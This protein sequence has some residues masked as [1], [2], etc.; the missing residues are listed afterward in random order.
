MAARLPKAARQYLDE[1]RQ[2]LSGLSA[3]EREDVLAHTRAQLVR[4][5]RRGRH[6]QD[7]LDSLGPVQR[8]AAGFERVEPQELKVSSGFEFL[9]RI[10]AWPTFAFSLLTAAVLLFAP[11]AP[12]S[13]EVAGALGLGFE[14]EVSFGCIEAR[15]AGTWFNAE[16]LPAALVALVPALFSLTPLILRDKAAIW[17]QL[18]GA[19]VMSVVSILAGL[20]IGMFYW[21]VTVLLYSQA[22][23]PWVLLRS[24]MGRA[25]WIWRTIGAVLLLATL[26]LHGQAVFT[27]Y[28]QL[29]LLVFP[30]ILLLPVFGHF[31]RWWWADIALIAVGLGVII[32]ASLAWP[33]MI[34]GFIAGGLFFIVGHLGLAGNMWY[35]RSRDLLALL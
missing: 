30:A 6:K 1:L 19:V 32:Y 35:R 28:H 33:V 5:P 26:L 16:L 4:L 27:L 8:I 25:G 7:I 9:T 11:Q 23:V 18:L 12:M 10:L 3:A 14:G 17:L 15:Q 31:L 21:P 24:A 2:A 13:V 22:I 20:G 29:W 34:Y